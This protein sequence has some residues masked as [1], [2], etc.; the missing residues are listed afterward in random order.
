MK[1]KETILILSEIANTL[2]K[3]SLFKEASNITK[4]MNRIVVSQ[5]APGDST[6]DEKNTDTSKPPVNAKPTSD[7]EKQYQIAIQKLK[8]E[9]FSGARTPQ[10]IVDFV[11]AA[12]E[13]TNGFYYTFVKNNALTEKQYEAFKI[14]IKSILSR[15]TTTDAKETPKISRSTKMIDFIIGNLLK[16]YMEKNSLSIRDLIDDNKKTQ[17]KSAIEEK[18]KSE[19]LFA[20]QKDLL[21]QHLERT[22]NSYKTAF[23]KNNIKIAQRKTNKYKAEDI[24]IIEQNNGNFLDVHNLGKLYPNEIFTAMQAQSLANRVYKRDKNLIDNNITFQVRHNDNDTLDIMVNIQD[25]LK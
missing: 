4:I 10:K 21:L 5:D 1:S 23:I 6:R 13:D 14:Q 11:F 3:K 22:L 20:N 16:K 25:N 19:Q 15:Y 12:K 8:N 2:D 17:I 9:L 18:I 24:N 7:Q